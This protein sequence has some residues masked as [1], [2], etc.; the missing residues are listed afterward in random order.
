LELDVF[1]ELYVPKPWPEGQR[2]AEAAAYKDLIEEVKLADR[3]GFK[4][5][6][7]AEHHFREVRSHVAAPEVFIGALSQVTEQ[8]RLGFGV[9]L[10]PHGFG[11]PV[12]VAEKVATA[13]VLSG[14]RVEWG[15]GR[16]TAMEQAA[17][18]VA[19]DDVSKE[20]WREAVQ[21]VVAAWRSEGDS[22]SWDGKYLQFPGRPE[23][24]PTRAILPK[25]TQDPHPPAWLAAASTGSAKA[26]GEAGLGLLLFSHLQTVDAVAELIEIYRE[27]SKNA[28]PLT[29]V[30]NNRVGVFTLV[31]CADSKD[32]L[33]RNGVWDAVRWWYQTFAEATLEWDFRQFSKEQQDALYGRVKKH[34][35]G[36]FDE[37]AFSDADMIIIGDVEECTEKLRRFAAAGVD[38]MLCACN[39]GPMPHEKVLR[40]IELLGTEVLPE[41]RR[42]DVP[43]T[44]R[45]ATD[46]APPAFV[47]PG[48]FPIREAGE[49]GISPD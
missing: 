48:N 14:G 34:A 3:V 9:T 44:A 15:T 45:G 49:S 31:H 6:W 46:V 2:A 5:A 12:R 33:E 16:S 10:M 39:F 28:E 32:D 22:F 19:L 13:D 27:A 40:S 36:D 23:A 29:D 20:Q 42:S 25:P 35:D 43:A 18:G 24:H 17:F 47:T 38:Q 26:A 41:L 1:S 30:V 11:H 37:R 8:I 4:T 21:T 7:L